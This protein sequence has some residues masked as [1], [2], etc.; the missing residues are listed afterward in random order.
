MVISKN[1]HHSYKEIGRHDDSSKAFS[2][3][4]ELISEKPA[5]DGSKEFSGVPGG[6]SPT[7]QT[8]GNE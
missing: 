7:A 4:N 8:A 1:L 5:G 6:V 3:Y 2:R